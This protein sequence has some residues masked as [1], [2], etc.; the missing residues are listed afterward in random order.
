MK[1]AAAEP[2]RADG[3]APGTSN[4]GQATAAPPYSGRKASP[5]RPASPIGCRTLMVGGKTL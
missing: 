1:I 5:H 4:M 2:E 3:R